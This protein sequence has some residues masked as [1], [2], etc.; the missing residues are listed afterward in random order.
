[1][2]ENPLRRHRR[3]WNYNIETNLREIGC[4]GMDWI[5]LAKDTA[6]FNMVMGLRVP[7]SAEN[8]LY[9]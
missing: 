8:F 1:V 9:G 4:G 7:R 3:R 6:L 5:H 2:K